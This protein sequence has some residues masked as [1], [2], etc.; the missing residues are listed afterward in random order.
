MLFKGLTVV[1]IAS[2]RFGSHGLAVLI[3]DVRLQ[4]QQTG[5]GALNGRAKTDRG[6]VGSHV[7]RRHLRS[8][9]GNV[10]AL[11]L[12]HLHMTEQSCAG[13]PTTGLRFVFQMHR[14]DICLA[15]G[16]KQRRDVAVKGVVAVGPKDGLCSIDIDLRFTHRAFK[17]ETDLLARRGTEGRAIP[18]FTNVGQTARASRLDRCLRL[19]VLGDCHF[20]Q[21]V[22]TREGTGDCP[23]MGNIY[24]L[25]VLVIE[26][27]RFCALGST[28]MET[29]TVGE[30][31]LRAL[32][33]KKR[34]RQRHERHQKER[35]EFH[36]LEI[37]CVGQKSK[38]RNLRTH[39]VFEDFFEGVPRFSEPGTCLRD[40]D[41]CVLFEVEPRGD[42]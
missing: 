1:E 29:P 34:G 3:H 2:V 39:R 40:K 26:I 10:D 8:P 30:V 5:I 9:N 14:Q 18:S 35:R 13:I 31:L 27:R 4:R 16:T 32:G 28:L 36:G 7:R 25:P 17:D 23:V 6:I 37:V 33:A 22:V 41:R 20:L 21:V 42:R 19:E 38:K 15:V 12:H 24:T 11:R